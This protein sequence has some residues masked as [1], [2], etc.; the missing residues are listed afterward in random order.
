MKDFYDTSL[1]KIKL[2]KLVKNQVAKKIK[3]K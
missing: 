1:L 3:N 2:N